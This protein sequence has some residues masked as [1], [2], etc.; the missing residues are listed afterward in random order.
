[1]NWDHL[2]TLTAWI[3]AIV[4]FG[5]GI[6]RYAD[7]REQGNKEPFLKQQLELCF[8]ASASAAR[9]TTESDPT[10]WNEAR[11]EF[12]RLYFGPLCVVEDEKV[13]EAMVA[14]GDLL[15]KPEDKIPDQAANL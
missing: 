7:A 15:P 1:M 6:Y 3:G 10:K 13:Q 8:R 11:L 12:W 5:W 14:L 2:V 4:T 9:L